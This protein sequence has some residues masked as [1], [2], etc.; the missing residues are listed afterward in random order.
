M[1]SKLFGDRT[2]HLTGSV[3]QSMRYP[4]GAATEPVAGYDDLRRRWSVLRK[5]ERDPVIAA[6]LAVKRWLPIGDGWRVYAAGPDENSRERAGFVRWAFQQMLGT[7]EG[8]ISDV[9]DA[10]GIGF[11]VLE[12]VYHTVRTGPYAGKIVPLRFVP[13][14]PSTIGFEMDERG[15]VHAITIT[16]PG[17]CHAKPYPPEKFVRYAHEPRYGSPYGSGD[18][19]RAYRSWWSKDNALK[20]WAVYVEKYGIIPR[21]AMY[22]DGASVEFQ[23]EL[24]DQLRVSAA[25]TEFVLPRSVQLQLLQPTGDGTAF[26]RFVQYHDKELA[27][28]VLGNTLLLDEGHR[29]G[30]LALGRV[31]QSVVES[32]V[33]KLKREIEDRVMGEQVIRPLIELNYGDSEAM[34]RFALPE[35]SREDVARLSDAIAKLT[36]AGAVDPREPWIRDLLGWPTRGGEE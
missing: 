31:H 30:S 5:M 16:V 22:E 29:V 36:K 6:A 26:E 15:D 20:W 7:V 18:L 19:L 9:L 24:L 35:P 2:P 4:V 27:K 1:M 33:R 23:Q 25:N 34:P 12:K 32:R 14:D 13:K 3:L 10:V 28:A 21:V 8:L 17:V 11:S